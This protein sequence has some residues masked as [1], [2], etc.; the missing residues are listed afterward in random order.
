MHGREAQTFKFATASLFHRIRNNL[1]IWN[2]PAK[3]NW[4]DATLTHQDIDGERSLQSFPKRIFFK[5]SFLRILGCH[6]RINLNLYF[7]SWWEYFRIL[8]PNSLSRIFHHTDYI[9]LATDSKSTAM[10]NLNL[11]H[12]TDITS[13]NSALLALITEIQCNSEQHDIDI[14]VLALSGYDNLKARRDTS[15]RVQLRWLSVIK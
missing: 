4:L 8:P 11:P 15:C 3:L 12:M 1:F 6:W 9:S 2:L 14:S 13:T 7:K 10:I 5:A